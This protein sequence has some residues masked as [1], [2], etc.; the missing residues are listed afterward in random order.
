MWRTRLCCYRV[1]PTSL[2]SFIEAN[3]TATKDAAAALHHGTVLVVADTDSDSIYEN[4]AAEEALIRGLSLEKHQC[5]LLYYVNRPCVVVGRNQNIFQEVALRRAAHDG[6]DV[7]RRA[8][9][10]G[11]VFHD[12]HNLCFS[13][14]THRSRYAPEK[15][16][17]LVRLGLSAAYGVDP[18][19]ITTTARHDLFLDGKKITGSAMRVQRDIAYHHCTLLVNTPHALLGRYLHPEGDYV[20]FQTSSVGSVRSPVTTLTESQCVPSVPNAMDVMKADMTDFFLSLGHRML[21]AE[22]PWEMDIADLRRTFA[23]T[24]AAQASA[25]LHRLGVRQAVL[26]DM[27]FVEGEGRRYSRGD[28]VTLGEAVQKA[29]SRAWAYAMPT[30]TTTVRLAQE[31]FLHRLRSLASWPDVVQLSSLGEEELLEEVSQM[32]FA[33]A[34]ALRLH[35]TVDHRIITHFAVASD[36]SSAV[37]SSTEV[38]ASSLEWM[39]RYFATL[40]VGN[41][42]DVAVCGVEAPGDTSVLARGFLHEVGTAAPDLPDLARDASVVMVVRTLLTLW[43]EKNVFDIVSSGG[44]LSA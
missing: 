13:F 41:P 12:A 18:R 20:D 38:A 10:G 24:R 3:S 11:A 19:R 32:L 29:K 8:S 27:P 37:S 25:P 1:V 35:T 26:D 22:T 6:V 36:T 30:F 33:E 2:R 4:L 43:R 15:T 9:G 21:E 16:I 14:L 7:A 23:A 39:S 40:L 28:A 31:E 17:Q 5:L 42:C 44:A 34:Q